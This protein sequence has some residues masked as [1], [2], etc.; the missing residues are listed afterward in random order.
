M[1]IG[2]SISRQGSYSCNCRCYATGGWTR[3]MAEASDIRAPLVPTRQQLIVTEA[4]VGARS[5]LP[6][7]VRRC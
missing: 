1:M 3:H 4:L 5:D 6:P 7:S 2:T